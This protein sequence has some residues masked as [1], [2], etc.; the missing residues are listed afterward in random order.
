[1]VEKAKPG[2]GKEGKISKRGILLAR[3]GKDKKAW[4]FE[5]GTVVSRRGSQT[6]HH[7]LNKRRNGTEG[8]NERGT[9][10]NF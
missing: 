8:G 4:G 3:E 1:V 5:K 9:E 7:T 10:K 2:R 6:E